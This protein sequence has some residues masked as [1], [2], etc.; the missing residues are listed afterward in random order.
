MASP[1]EPGSLPRL[2]VSTIDDDDG[3]VVRCSVATRHD[4]DEIEKTRNEVD[5]VEC[6]G[7]SIDGVVV[8]ALE[9]M[10]LNSDAKEADKCVDSSL[11]SVAQMCETEY[12]TEARGDADASTT[13]S[14]RAPD[15]TPWRCSNLALPLHYV[16]A[17]AVQNITIGLL[18]GV[19]MGEFT[20]NQTQM[21]RILPCFM[22]Y[23]II[24]S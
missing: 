22:L 16:F 6:S 17:G 15:Q 12:C 23:Y 24:V 19:L 21:F 14:M 2:E 5:G 3:A 13:R 9:T 8:V 1:S 10:A 4:V 18:F 20:Q 7:A 11:N